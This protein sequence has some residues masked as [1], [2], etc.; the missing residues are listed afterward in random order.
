MRNV[1]LY[2]WAIGGGGGVDMIGRP[3]II[4]HDDQ[5]SSDSLQPVICI[6]QHNGGIGLID[7]SLGDHYL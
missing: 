1:N 4:A 6:G 3:R 7:R 5:S 2:I